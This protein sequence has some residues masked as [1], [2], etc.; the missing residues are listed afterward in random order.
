MD[1]QPTI[2]SSCP[3]EVKAALWAIGIK[4]QY[5]KGTLEQHRIDV[6]NKTKGWTW[7]PIEGETWEMLGF[8][9]NSIET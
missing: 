1:Q 4:K 3:D 6:L 7:C 2:T 9:K 8:P 5:W